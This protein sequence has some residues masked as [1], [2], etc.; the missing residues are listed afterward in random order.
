MVKSLKESFG[1]IRRE[2][3]HRKYKF[4]VVWTKVLVKVNFKIYLK[5]NRGIREIHK[6]L[7]RLSFT[8][9]A[10]GM[11]DA[12]IARAKLLITQAIQ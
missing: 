8:K 2:K 6:G 7:V 5:K 11:R 10:L 4:K 3:L 9:M 1:V 12:N